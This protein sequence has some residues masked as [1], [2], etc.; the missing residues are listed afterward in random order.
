MAHPKEDAKTRHIRAASQNR[1]C[2]RPAA[3]AVRLG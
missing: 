2:W 1:A 3:P